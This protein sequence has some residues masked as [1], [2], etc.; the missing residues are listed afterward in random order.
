VRRLGLLVLV[1]CSSA[2]PSPD[3]SVAFEYNAT[4]VWSTDAAPD[5]TSVTIDG[6]A[7]ASQELYS[8][9]ETYP[10]YDDARATFVPHQ[11]V[12]TTST[13][14]LTFEIDLGGCEQVPYSFGTPLTA[15]SDEFYASE[16]A[17]TISFFAGCGHCTSSDKSVGWCA[18]AR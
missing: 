18:R 9:H 17:G 16:M 4:G 1:G 7:Y 2:S 12:I 15:E 3:A 10:S 11:V 6:R 14:T 8:L 13:Q 5:I